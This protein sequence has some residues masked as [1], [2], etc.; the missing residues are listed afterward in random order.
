MTIEQIL[1]AF[2]LV[3]GI[4]GQLLVA[5]QNRKG[6]YWFIACNIGMIIVSLITELYRM[7]A[8]Y[9]FYIATCFYSIY[10]WKKYDKQAAVI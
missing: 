1:Q 3:T 8:L 7:A 9:L 2:I 10:K 6:F 4:A 5:H